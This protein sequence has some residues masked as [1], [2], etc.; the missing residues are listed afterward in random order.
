MSLLIASYF[1]SPDAG[2][3]FNCPYT[4]DDVRRLQR[5]V[6][7]NCTVEHQF[8]VITDKPELFADDADIR[9]IQIDWTTHVPGTCY[10]RLMSFHHNGKE[11][12]GADRLLQ[13]D[14][15]TLIVGNIDHLVNREEDLVMWRNPARHPS[16]PGRAIYNTSILSHRLGSVPELWQAFVDLRSMG[17]KI[18]AKDDQWYL[19]DAL[20]EDMPYF[21]GARDGVYRIARQDTPG[22]GVWGELPENACIVT[23]PG[24]EGKPDNPVIRAGNP[25]LERF[26]A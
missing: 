2:S 22:S 23:M 3:K 17:L 8:G 25:W 11:I 21:D 9:A 12:F 5:M 24:S 13:I 1:W 16:R 10:V 7:K 20:G 15:D 4:I 18:P 26:V 14:L 19:S 6:A